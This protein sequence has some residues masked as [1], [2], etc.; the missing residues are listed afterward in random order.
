M[1][2]TTTMRMQDSADQGLPVVCS[3]GCTA[4]AEPE[5]ARLAPGAGYHFREGSGTSIHSKL[6]IRKVRDWINKQETANDE[7][8]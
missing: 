8:W 3:T 5:G 1:R 2:M 6:K 7:Q 4:G